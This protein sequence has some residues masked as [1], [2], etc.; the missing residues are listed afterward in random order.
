MLTRGKLFAE[1]VDSLGHLSF[2]LD[3]R[4]AVGLFD[5]NKYCED[6]AKD[7]LNLIY[8]YDLKNL[9]EKRS[10]E[11]GLDLGDERNR[12]GIQ[13]TTQKK[14][15]KINNTL[16]KLTD[17]QKKEYK[18]IIVFILGKKQGSYKGVNPGLASGISF[19]INN[20][21]IDFYDLERDILTLQVAKVQE[22]YDFMNREVIR[23]YSELE[24][25]NTPTGEKTSI[26]KGVENIPEI[27]FENCKK[28]LDYHD[29]I[30]KDEDKTDKDSKFAIEINE[31][32]KELFETLKKLPRITRETFYILL[33]RADT[34]GTI[35]SVRDELIKRIIN[36]PMQRYYEEL[37][38]L[39]DSKLIQIDDDEPIK[40]IIDLVGPCIKADCL[41][42]IVETAKHFD[43]NLKEI[44]VDLNFN[45]LAADE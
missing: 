30:F 21:I 10:N 5:L 31:V 36:V 43:L 14:S 29:Y 40:R 12:I 42:Y 3:A 2:V 26:L 6:F 15:D 35:Y 16:E 7:L 22:I 8:D 28:I 44:L 9:N 13:V 32:C 27:E 41:W 34:N 1:I 37:S 33:D 38:L 25:E 4:S 17:D 23:L 19:D 18:R 11:P 24:V 39:E 45:L 20:D